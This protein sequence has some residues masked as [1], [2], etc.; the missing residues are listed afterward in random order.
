MFIEAHNFS[1]VIAWKKIP[2]HFGNDPHET[3]QPKPCELPKASA[4][5]ELLHSGYFMW[6]I[7]SSHWFSVETI[8][9]AP[10][11]LSF[12]CSQKL[13]YWAWKG[14]NVL[15]ETWNDMNITIWVLWDSQSIV[16]LG[17]NSES[18]LL[19]EG[20]CHPL[21]GDTG[22]NCLHTKEQDG[23]RSEVRADGLR[24]TRNITDQIR[25]YANG[26][27]GESCTHLERQRATCKTKQC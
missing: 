2:F 23:E 12:M 13:F 9:H 20:R 27:V 6:D 8:H 11:F 1:K 4:E 15:Q 7:F 3:S 14:K 10:L 25:P 19:L 5:T 24:L 22:V 18:D 21:T 17:L 16:R 26:G